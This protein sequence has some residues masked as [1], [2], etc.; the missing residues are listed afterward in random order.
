MS[1]TSA[2]IVFNASANMP[3]NNTGTS[4]GG[5]DVGSRVIFSDIPATDNVSVI[6]SSVADNTQT[7]TVYGRDAS[8]TIVNE[9]LSLNGTSRVTGSQLFERILK[10]VISAAHAGTVTLARDNGPTYTGITAMESG[11]LEIR[12]LFYDASSDIA[13][14]STRNFYEK[15]FIR[16]NHSTLA[17]N[18][19]VIKEQ[20]DPSGF[21]T[22]DLEDAKDDNNSVA[23]RLSAPAGMLG[24]FTNA[25]KNVPTTSLGPGES[26][27]VWLKL[28]LA[29]GESAAKNTYTIRITGTST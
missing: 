11:I 4:G 10:V 5:V 25:D 22:F 8:G 23:N 17:L 9:V 12:R 28:T 2:D 6:S 7:V 29:A 16:N 27:G 24:S 19:A 13:G 18:S 14:G 26:I 15:I 3:E 21:I 20:A 1:I